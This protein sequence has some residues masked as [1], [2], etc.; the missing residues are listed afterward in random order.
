MQLFMCIPL[1]RW[2]THLNCFNP[3]ISFLFYLNK[4][5]ISFQYDEVPVFYLPGIFNSYI[6]FIYFNKT[7]IPNLS[8]FDV[9]LILPEVLLYYIFDK[10][11]W[12][13]KKIIT[14]WFLLL[15]L[16]KNIFLNLSYCSMCNNAVLN[17]SKN[18][19]SNHIRF[20]R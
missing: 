11:I 8:S 12:W 18:H 3:Q 10:N 6:N 4:L 7:W 20:W 16:K 14:Q 17:H 19:R 9:V 5:L 13:S 2:E 1:G 15:T